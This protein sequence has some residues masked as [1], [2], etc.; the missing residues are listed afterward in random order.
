LI[1]AIIQMIKVAFE[2]IRQKAEGAVG[3]N[4]VT[5]VNFCC[6]GCCIACLDYCVKQISKNAYI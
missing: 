4:P 1:I 2:Y 6:V 5:K 3:N